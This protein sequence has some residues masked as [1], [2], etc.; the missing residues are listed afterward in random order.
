M[1]KKLYVAY[2]SNLNKGQMKYRCPTAKYVGTGELQGYELQFKGRERS[3][4]ATIGR[5]EGASVPVGLW[6]IQTRD[7]RALDMYEGF[8]ATISSGMCRCRWMARRS[9][10]WCIS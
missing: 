1:A 3:A 7:E 9:A 4:F 10:P 5:K 8:P 2:G 6:E